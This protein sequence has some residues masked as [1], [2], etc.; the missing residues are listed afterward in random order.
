MSEKSQN[1]FFKSFSRYFAVRTLLIVALVW[2]S[3]VLILSAFLIYG[4]IKVSNE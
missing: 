2:V 1:V 4:T 3:I